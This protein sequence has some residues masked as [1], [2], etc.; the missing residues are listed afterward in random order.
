MKLRNM[1]LAAAVAAALGAA[2]APVLA[3][4]TEVGQIKWFGSIYAKFLDGNRRFENAAALTIYDMCK[5]MNKG[6]R[7]ENLHLVSKTGG[8]SGD[9]HANP[10]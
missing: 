7:I 1:T 10:Q 3:Q 4:S 9:Y 6:I 5:A 2:P 8:K